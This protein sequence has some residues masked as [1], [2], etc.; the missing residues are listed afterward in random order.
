MPKS[1]TAKIKSLQA[2]EILDSRGYPTLEVKISLDSGLQAKASVPS[3]SSH[4][5][6]SVR[7]LYDGDRHRFKGKGVLLAANHIN[8]IVAKRLIGLDPSDQEG[9]DRLLIEIDGSED[10]S[11]L[12]A[13]AMTAVSLVVARVAALNA[14][15]E[16][17]VY[18]REHFQLKESPSLP[19]PVFS[20]FNG[21]HYADTNLDFNEF[22]LLPN[23]Q[24]PVFAATTTENNMN[25]MI[26]GGAEVFHSL[27]ALLKESGYD[28]DTGSEGGYAPDMDSSIQAL[29]MLQAAVIKAGY[30]PGKDFNLGLDI[31][32]SHLYDPNTKKYVF[33]LGA[34][35]LSAQSLLELYRDWLER[36]PLVYLE[37]GLSDN[38]WQSWREASAALGD[39]LVLAG[40]ELFASDIKRLRQGIAQKAANAIVIKPNAVGTLTEA[41]ECAKLAQRQH[42]RIVVSHRRGETNDDFI[43][44][45]AVALGASYLKAGA[46]SRGERV[47][48]YNRL[49]EIAS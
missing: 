14:E 16:L 34:S 46:L 11:Q 35:Y 23:S 22:L 21:G 26:R 28:A 48:K 25:R 1:K 9:I 5:R 13:N 7:D 38:D 10:R 42:Y 6:F 43:V 41:I 36:Y 37:D 12:G 30:K 19:L 24:S 29:E 27:G 40:D 18:L 4:E 44:D 49:A 20:M 39:K 33:P 2:R 45:L 32:S 15:Q 8:E 31:G 17:F 3:A 47:A